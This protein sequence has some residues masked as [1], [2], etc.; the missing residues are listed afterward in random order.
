MELNC[1]H[2]VLFLEFFSA[3]K[4]EVLLSVNVFVIS[5]YNKESETAACDKD[6]YAE[7]KISTCP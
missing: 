3:D 7:M 4:T 6:D 2:E 5:N 1:T